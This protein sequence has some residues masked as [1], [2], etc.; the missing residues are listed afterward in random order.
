[1]SAS[2]KITI[3]PSAATMPALDRR[4]LAPVRD[5]QE[6]ELAGGRLGP[7]PD[8]VGRA[9]GAAVVHDEDLDPLRE[10]GRPGSALAARPAPVQVAEQLVERGAEP[11]LLV[12]GGQDDGQRTGGH[13]GQSR[14]RRWAASP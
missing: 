8:E 9:V 14:P 1:M 7:S 3:S 4:A 13:A 6:L 12:V 5:R 2:V 11:R 10:L